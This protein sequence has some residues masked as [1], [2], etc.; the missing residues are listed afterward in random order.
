M[1][2]VCDVVELGT[3]HQVIMGSKPSM[4]DDGSAFAI[5]VGEE[6]DE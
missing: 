6:F 1:Y 2:T 5:F 4:G 3:A